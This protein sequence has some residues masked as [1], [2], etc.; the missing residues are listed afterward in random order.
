[1]SFLL[2]LCS[3]C[4]CINAPWW[5]YFWKSKI[6][7][8]ML[9]QYIT[10]VFPSAYFCEFLTTHLSLIRL[11]SWGL[12]KFSLGIGKTGHDI[13]T[14]T[15]NLE[16]ICRLPVLLTLFPSNGALLGAMAN[17]YSTKFVYGD[18]TLRDST[19]RTFCGMIPFY[20]RYWS[21]FVVQYGSEILLQSCSFRDSTSLALRFKPFSMFF[22]PVTKDWELARR[23]GGK[24]QVW[25]EHLINNLRWLCWLNQVWIECICSFV[26]PFRSLVVG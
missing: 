10:H 22:F 5:V 6:S 4:E 11:V 12:E 3:I 13:Q 24:G 21:F 17:A 19:F 14:Q 2:S 26:R 18:S 8:G 25:W 1:M 9:V 16:M 20:S 15:R 23:L 7:V